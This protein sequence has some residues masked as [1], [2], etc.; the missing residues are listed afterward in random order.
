MENDR[1]LTPFE[2][3]KEEFKKL[4]P[5]VEIG[6]PKPE[7]NERDSL[8][9]LYRAIHALNPCRAALCLSG[10]GIRSATFSLGV[11]QG[12]ARARWLEH[13]HYLSTVSGGGYIGGWLSAWIR[14]SG[15]GDVVAGLCAHKV[16][17]QTSLRAGRPWVRSLERSDGCGP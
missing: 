5:G 17:D 14:R 16:Q 12:L 2:V 10:G 15:L 6:E 3:L 8:E 7:E 1:Y 13:F 11:I 4:H 9:K